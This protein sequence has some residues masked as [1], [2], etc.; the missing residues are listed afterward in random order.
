MESLWEHKSPCWVDPTSLSL[1]TESPL[2]LSAS[3]RMMSVL[4]WVVAL[5]LIV[6]VVSAIF[7]ANRRQQKRRSGAD[8]NQ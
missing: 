5:G 4:G 7:M 6:A 2:P 8:S 1:L 3:E